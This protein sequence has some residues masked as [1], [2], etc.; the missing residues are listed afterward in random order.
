MLPQHSFTVRTFNLGTDIAL[1][2]NVLIYAHI[3]PNAKVFV[4]QVIN[5]WDADGH[6]SVYLPAQILMEFLNVIIWHRF[7][8][9]LLLP[10]AIQI[11]QD[12]CGY[13]HRDYVSPTDVT[14]DAC[15]AAQICHHAKEKF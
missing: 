9:P 13:R 3:H 7:E 14:F 2:T 1:Y 12:Y 15:R 4:E 8:A 11:V 6:L 10:D 5:P